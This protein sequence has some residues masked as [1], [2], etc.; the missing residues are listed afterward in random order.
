MTIAFDTNILAYAAGVARHAD[1]TAKVATSRDLLRQAQARIV[2]VVP[3]QALGE[4]FHVLRRTDRSA[5]DALEQVN[6]LR[7]AV[8]VAATTE[9][10]LA[11]ALATAAR[12]SLQV[13]DAIIIVAAANA[14]ARFLLTEDMHDGLAV[15][16]LALVNPFAAGDGALVPRLLA[17]P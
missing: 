13:W 4:L 6:G 15:H 3:A 9:R 17:G 12:Y 11:E 10:V 7:A 5:R 14:G 1:D 16:G 8:T 2:P